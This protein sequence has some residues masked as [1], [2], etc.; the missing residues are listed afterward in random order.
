MVRSA[1]K[2]CCSPRL[3]VRTVGAVE[4]LEYPDLPL[5]G[6]RIVRPR[7]VKGE[8]DNCPLGYCNTMPEIL[9]VC[10]P[11]CKH[12]QAIAARTSP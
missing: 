9:A 2:L 7:V 3:Q 6:L 12:W 5:H 4:S 8:D 10:R 11:R 1:G